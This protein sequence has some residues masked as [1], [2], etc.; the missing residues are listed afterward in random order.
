MKKI[1][2]TLFKQCPVQGRR[3][4]VTGY[5]LGCSCLICLFSVWQD[6][7]CAPM[8]CDSIKWVDPNKQTNLCFQILFSSRWIKHIFRCRLCLNSWVPILAECQNPY[9]VVKYRFLGISSNVLNQ[10]ILHCA[11]EIFGFFKKR[12][13][14]IPQRNLMNGWNDPTRF[15]QNNKEKILF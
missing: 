13:T 14:K 8:F 9:K 1:L 6:N 12:L 10:N 4:V 15:P 7:L 3:F 11:L 2:N 5:F